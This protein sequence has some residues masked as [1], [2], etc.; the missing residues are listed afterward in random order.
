MSRRPLTLRNRGLTQV[1][2]GC[3]AVLLLVLVSSR[4]LRAQDQNVYDDDAAACPARSVVAFT[5][6]YTQETYAGYADRGANS[7]FTRVYYT[8]K[9]IRSISGKRTANGQFYIYGVEC[10]LATFLSPFGALMPPMERLEFVESPLL[11]CAETRPIAPAYYEPEF[12]PY[13]GDG[14]AEGPCSGSGGGSGEDEE[15]GA[16]GCRR[17]YLVVERSDNGGPWYVIWEGWGIVCG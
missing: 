1:I 16:G 14:G 15:E 4:E 17:E 7:Y 11:A 5:S 12:E 2:A 10:R 3:A 6:P 8:F 13:D 9:D